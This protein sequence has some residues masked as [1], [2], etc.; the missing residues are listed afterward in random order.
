MSELQATPTDHQP[1]PVPFGRRKVNITPLRSAESQEPNNRSEH[2]RD[3]KNHVV[4]SRPTKREHED[5]S[6]MGGSGSRKRQQKSQPIIID[7]TEDAW[8][9]VIGSWRC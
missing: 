3:D 6:S 9:G 2:A 4:A 5:R 7:L 1:V 8:S